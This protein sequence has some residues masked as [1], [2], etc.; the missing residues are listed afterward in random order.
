[1]PA[2]LDGDALGA[3]GD[4]AGR[5][6]G[7]PGHVLAEQQEQAAGHPVGHFDAVIAQ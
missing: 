6:R 3:A 2:E 5:Q 7:D 1:V 4:L